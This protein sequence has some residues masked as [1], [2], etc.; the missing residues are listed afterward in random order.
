MSNQEMVNEILNCLGGKDN[1]ITAT[2]CMTRLRIHVKQDN[3][4]QDEALKN[5]EGVL[6]L[7]HD[8]AKHALYVFE[9]AWPCP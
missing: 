7:V 5:I 8:R 1:V 6:G 4:I 3:Q 2:N 9:R